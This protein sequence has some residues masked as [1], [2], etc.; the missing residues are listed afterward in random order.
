MAGSLWAAIAFFRAF[1][2]TG[3]RHFA[4]ASVGMSFFALIA[5]VL[6]PKTSFYP[7]SLINQ[8]SFHAAL[9]LPVQPIQM[10]LA[11]LITVTVSSYYRVCSNFNVLKG[12]IETFQEW[13]FILLVFFITV[14]GWFSANTVGNNTT[15]T[16]RRNLIS[17]ASLAASALDTTLVSRLSGSP[18]DLDNPAYLMIKQKLRTMRESNPDLRFIYLMT[19]KGEHVVFMVDSEPIESKDYSPPGEVYAE[20]SPELFAA[21]K[22]C[23]KFIEGPLPDSWGVW[24]SGLVPIIEP[25]SHHLLG[26]FGMD[27]DA[28]DWQQQI[29][30]DRTVPITRTLLILLFVV[31]CFF[32]QHR[33]WLRTQQSLR[34]QSVLLELAKADAS[35][36]NSALQNITQKAAGT[37]EVERVSIWR[38]GKDQAEIVCDDLYWLNTEIHEQGQRLLAANYPRYFQA[39]E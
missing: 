31:F 9:G 14:V 8:E 21:F 3:N 4:C 27:I 35:D 28:K 25:H 30:R 18:K 24:V 26:M 16:M 1:K 10:L 20:A 17:R 19:M 23:M 2:S 15:E 38:Y 22:S 13:W 36:L 11:M 7:S 12:K 39:L 32:Y 34:Y 29:F 37:L 6:V 5:C 33:V